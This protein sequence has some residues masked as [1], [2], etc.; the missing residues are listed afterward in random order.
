LTQALLQLAQNAVKHTSSGDVVAVGSAS[1]PDGSLTFWVRDT[2]P[3][4][5]DSDKDK[6][7][8]RFVRGPR[9]DKDEGSGLGLSIVT[10]IAQAHGGSVHVEDAH[11]CGARF[12]ITLPRPRKD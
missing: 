2:G 3:G 7:F 4:V 9:A 5:P 11:P 1:R 10:A 8:N 12:V 6:I